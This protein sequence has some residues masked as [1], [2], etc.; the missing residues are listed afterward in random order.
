MVKG[1]TAGNLLAELTQAALRWAHQRLAE[2]LRPA[3]AT[4]T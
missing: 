1:A 3:A 2:G 4:D